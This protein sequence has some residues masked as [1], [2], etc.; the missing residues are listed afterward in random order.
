MKFK[1]GLDTSISPQCLR[2]ISILNK[3]Q[4]PNIVKLLDF[5][6]EEGKAY[7]IFE[8]FPFD[9]KKFLMD[10]HSHAT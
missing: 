4:H 2:E 9:L 7:L 5:F 8:Y 10:P 3:I 6:L 1:D